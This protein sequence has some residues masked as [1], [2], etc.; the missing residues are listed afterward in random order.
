M[1]KLSKEAFAV[2][3]MCEETKKPFGITVDPRGNNCYAF[4]WAFKIG[5]KSAKHEG[6]D[7]KSVHGAIM[8]DHDFNG[9][10]YCGSK[11]FYICSRCGKI[12]CY[13]DQESV[14]CPNCGHTSIVKAANEVNLKGGG[15]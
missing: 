8:Y 4:V 11:S 13:H 15:F 2:M 7:Q 9:C 10:P 5:E 1:T 3:A 14:E 12:V 6:F